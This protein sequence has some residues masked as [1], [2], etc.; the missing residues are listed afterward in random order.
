MS[1][2]GWTKPAPQS[3]RRLS[4]NSVAMEAVR[5]PCLPL[6][7]RAVIP[8]LAPGSDYWGYSGLVLLTQPVLTRLEES[9]RGPA[10]W[11]FDC[12]TSLAWRGG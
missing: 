6:I 10:M 11:R 3:Y 5:P 12:A 9:R 2:I 1:G 7:D 8:C 4:W